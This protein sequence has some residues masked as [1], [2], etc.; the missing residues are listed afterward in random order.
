MSKEEYTAMSNQSNS[1]A[2]GTLI[3]GNITSRTDLC[4]DGE[5]EGKIDCQGRVTVG[6]EGKVVGDI[7]CVNA[8][9]RGKVEGNLRVAD[10]L[11]LLSTAN[12]K[13][14]VS[15]KVLVIEPQAVFCGSCDMKGSVSAPVSAPGTASLDD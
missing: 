9:I 5:V 12:V 11:S 10:T 2:Q 13:G 15:T 7:V 4:V 6:A 14:D 8:D 1:I 3:K